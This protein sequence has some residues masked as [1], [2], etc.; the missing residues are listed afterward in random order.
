MFNNISLEKEKQALRDTFPYFNQDD[1]KEMKIYKVFERCARENVEEKQM[2]AALQDLGDLN[3][4]D[5]GIRNFVEARISELEYLQK[6]NQKTN[7]LNEE[8]E[9]KEENKESE[10]IKEIKEESK[11]IEE[12]LQN[13][14]IEYENDIKTINYEQDD[15]QINQ[16]YF[17]ENKEEINEEK[18][19][20][21]DLELLKEQNKALE[22]EKTT[23]EEFDKKIEEQTQSKYLNNSTHNEQMERIQKDAVNNKKIMDDNSLEAVHSYYSYY[24]NN[25]TDK[26][27]M[28]VQINYDGND[29]VEINFAHKG[30]ET[31]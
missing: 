24:V 31:N 7:D 5:I 18:E 30:E 25:Q 10:E 26:S 16:A 11:K 17:E 28:D 4:Y 20:K 1:E 2:I 8:K 3:D 9:T 22:K 12:N 29:K 6:Q 13:R 19:L 23:G 21:N 14:N 27:K 15:R